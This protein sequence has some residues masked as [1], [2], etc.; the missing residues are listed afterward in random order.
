MT[1]EQLIEAVAGEFA[2][3]HQSA[4][5]PSAQAFECDI[6]AR[7][8]LALIERHAV[9]VPIEPGEGEIE[10][11]QKGANHEIDEYECYCT[12]EMARGARAALLK[13]HEA[14]T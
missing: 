10:T 3:Q 14:K 6:A 8:I 2:R 9:I 5:Y 12:S 4:C 1:R 11:I 7:A 13:Y